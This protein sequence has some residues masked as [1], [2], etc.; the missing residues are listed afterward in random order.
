MA[1]VRPHF[2][3]HCSLRYHRK[4]AAIY[5]DNDLLALHTRLGLLAIERW[6]AKEGGTLRIHRSELSALTGGKRR[7]KAEG[8]LTRLAT[9]LELTCNL[10]GTYWEVEWEKLEEKQGFTWKKVPTIVPEPHAPEAIGAAPPP[11]GEPPLVE[12]QKKRIPTPS[13]TPEQLAEL[14]CSDAFI[15]ERARRSGVSH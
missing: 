3:T 4:T 9:Y 10:V 13:P 5:G 15:A 12:P 8:L 6:A 1:R 11:T 2:K 7:D 14:G